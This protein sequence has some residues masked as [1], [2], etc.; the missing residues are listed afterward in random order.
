MAAAAPVASPYDWSGFYIGENGGYGWGKANT[1]ESPGDVAAATGVSP[2][3]ASSTAKGAVG[4]ITE[5]FNWQLNSKWVTGLETDF[6][7]SSIAGSGT[8]SVSNL[9]ALPFNFGV[10]GVSQKTD[11]FGTVRARLGYLPT[12]NLMIF[13]TAG[14]AYGKINEAGNLTLTSPGSTVVEGTSSSIFLCSNPPLVPFGG[15]TCF[16]GMQTRTSV[17]WTAGFGAEY[18]FYRN[19]SLKFEYLYVDLGSKTLPL[20]AATTLGGLCAKCPQCQNRGSVQY[21]SGRAELG[22]EIELDR[23]K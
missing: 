8:A 12:D 3:T 10:L 18:G 7:L 17:G 1:S 4:G 5:G 21:R 11:W 13:G 16:S 9:A 15:P 22:S 14:V 19:F 23:Y 2:V 20:S 6:Q